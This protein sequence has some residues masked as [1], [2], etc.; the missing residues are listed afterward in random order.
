MIEVY[1][2]DKKEKNQDP[3]QQKFYSYLP[4]IFLPEKLSQ[5][6]TTKT[7]NIQTMLNRGK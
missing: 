1:L 3:S 2:M 4:D 7:N 6:C 5:Y